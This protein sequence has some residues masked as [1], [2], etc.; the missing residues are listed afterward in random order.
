MQGKEIPIRIDMSECKI[1]GCRYLQT[2]CVTCGRL[3]CDRLLPN[4]EW[5]NIKNGL[6]E[7]EEDVLVSDGKRCSVSC[8]DS[9]CDIWRGGNILYNEIKLWMPLPE[10]PKD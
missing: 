7:E 3:V 1:R 6:P 10:P 5:V 2:T 8:F 9:N 4:M